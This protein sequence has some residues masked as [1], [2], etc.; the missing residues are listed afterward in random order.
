MDKR[1]KKLVKIEI[2]T[3]KRI[4]PRKNT[5]FNVMN[6]EEMWTCMIQTGLRRI[7]TVANLNEK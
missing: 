2:K 4:S 5:N 1:N 3:I 6:T 7:K